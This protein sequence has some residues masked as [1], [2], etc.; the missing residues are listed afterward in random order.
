[1]SINTISYKGYVA[2]IDFDSRDEIFV[3]RILGI[4]DVISFHA[5]TVTGLRAEFENAVDDFLADCAE[6]GIKPE[7]TP[8]G[9]LMLRI[10]PEVHSAAAIAA[11]SEGKSLNQ[12]AAEAL[13]RAASH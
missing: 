7:K 6:R 2:R 1:M 9:R 13:E 8:S 10:P 5:D 11:E 12:W 4:S 3:G